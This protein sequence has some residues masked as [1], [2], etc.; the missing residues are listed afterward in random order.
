M[1]DALVVGAGP[2]GLTMAA[3]LARQGVDCRLIERQET[4]SPFSRALVVQARTCE[5]FDDFGIIGTLLPRGQPMTAYNVVGPGGKRARMPM[6]SFPWLETHYPIP[7]MVRQSDTEEALSGYL[8]SLGVQVEWGVTF[9]D[10]TQDAEGVEATLRHGDGTVETVRARWLLGCDGAHSRVRKRSRIPYEGETYPD[11][12]L[13]ADVRVDW[14]LGQGELFIMPS[15]HGMVVAIPMP[16]AFRY[17]LTIIR[18]H[19]G[20]DESA[21]LSLQE[22]Q[23]LVDR[24]VPVPTHLSEPVWMTRYRMHRRG[25]ARYREGRV[26]LAGDA[27]H[28]HSP[29]GGQGMNTGI[30]DAYNLGWKLAL[31]TKGLAPESLLDTYQVERLRV[32]QKLMEGTD[33][34]FAMLSH[35]GFGVKMLRAHVMP[36][37]AQVLFKRTFMQQQLVRFVSELFIHYRHSPLSTESVSG[38]DVGGVRLADAPAPGERLPDLAL[39]GEGVSRLHDVLRGP[40][41]TLLLFAGLASDGVAPGALVSL[42]RRLEEARGPE[43]LRAWVVVAGEARGRSLLEDAKG[44]VHRR[45]GA[46]AAC[47][48][49]VRPD[50]YVGFRARPIEVARLERELAARMGPPREVAARPDSDWRPTPLG[51]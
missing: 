19:H 28:I 22:V 40:H 4:P 48:F 46:G 23:A 9:E 49:L 24:M 2:T 18:P 8:A 37:A 25:V 1:L 31:V 47:L 39:R 12:S 20:G 34:R 17:R 27:A 36:R 32:G 35:G 30:Q 44:E 50:G 7:L 33:K 10:F 29:L 5:L 14:P 41:H 43:R 42:A 51:L 11:A 26:F 15:L 38:E 3:S 16:G 13:L 6:R 21:T 45:F